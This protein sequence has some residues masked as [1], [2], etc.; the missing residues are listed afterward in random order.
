[1]S[2]GA[3]GFGPIWRL[4]AARWKSLKHADMAIVAASSA[5]RVVLLPR[6]LPPIVKDAPACAGPVCCFD[7]ALPGEPRDGQRRAGY[8][9]AT[10][11]RIGLDAL[12]RRHGSLQQGL[13]PRRGPWSRVQ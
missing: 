10:P 2:P 7:V 9:P 11:Q 6:M 1:M 8:A 13:Y 5:T 3:A 12:L 4:D